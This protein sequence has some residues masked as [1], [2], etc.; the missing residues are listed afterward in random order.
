MKYL[1]VAGLIVWAGLMV[2]VYQHQ[3]EHDTCKVSCIRTYHMGE[4]QLVSGI[5]FC[6]PDGRRWTEVP[7]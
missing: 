4:M 6:S 2:L 7:R 1:V 3:Q 5:C